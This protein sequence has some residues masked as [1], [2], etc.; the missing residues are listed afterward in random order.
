MKMSSIRK[1]RIIYTDPDA[2]DYSS[3]EEVKKVH[4][5]LDSQNRFFKEILLPKPSPK[6][7]L[8]RGKVT[9]KST[10][11]YKGVRLRRW[12]RF[13]AEI[14]DPIRKVKVWIGTFDTELEAA[15]AYAKKQNEFKEALQS[16]NAT[17]S[18]VTKKL[19]SKQKKK[20]KK[21]SVHSPQSSLFAPSA[22]EGSQG[23][24]CNIIGQ[25]D[26]LSR[27][28]AERCNVV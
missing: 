4:F 15:E 17:N 27:D 28:T 19:R 7:S 2:T 24:N 1:I 3:D 11:I 20:H 8:V 5:Q 13:S 10:S 9:P 6:I 12:G 26:S 23:E 25:G 14:R 21:V 18:K 16:G 22:I